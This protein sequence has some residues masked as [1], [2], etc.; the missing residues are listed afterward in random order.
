MKRLKTEVLD[1]LEAKEMFKDPLEDEVIPPLHR[2]A[3]LYD[4]F[5]IQR[6]ATKAHI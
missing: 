2:T 6:L 3:H 4:I 5:T 1:R